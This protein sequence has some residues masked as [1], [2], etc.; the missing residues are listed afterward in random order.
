MFLAG[1]LDKGSAPLPPPLGAR[2]AAVSQAHPTPPGLPRPGSQGAVAALASTPASQPPPRAPAWGGAGLAAAAPAPVVCAGLGPGDAGSAAALVAAAAGAGAGAGAGAA[3]GAGAGAG[4]QG[5][6]GTGAGVEAGAG[7]QQQGSGAPLGALRELLGPQLLSGSI[8]AAAGGRGAGKR[9]GKG[10]A[11]AEPHGAGF[12]TPVGKGR[13]GAPQPAATPANLTPQFDMSPFQAA[14]GSPVP[15]SLHTAS[16]GPH[17]PL[18]QDGV[19]NPSI[20]SSSGP[21]LLPPPGPNPSLYAASSS[22]AGAAA[23]TRAGWDPHTGGGSQGQG[24]SR[25]PGSAPPPSLTSSRTPLAPAVTS[26]SQSGAQGQGQG[27]GLPGSGRA[28]L[29]LADFIVPKPS[30]GSSTSLNSLG[31]G[32]G[33]GKEREAG[34]PGREAAAAGGSGSSIRAGPPSSPGSSSAA[35][36]WG[37]VVPGSSPP[38]GLAPQLSLRDI[39]VEQEKRRATLPVWAGGRER[40]AKASSGGTAVLGSSPPATKW[41]VPEPLRPQAIQHIQTEESAIKALEKLYG[42]GVSV[43]RADAGCTGIGGAEVKRS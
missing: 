32:A 15:F 2:G 25:T 10:G 17:A 39:Q 3:A 28:G 20:Q 19:P 37:G 24:A 22:G 43:M 9:Q 33:Q 36:V 35:K 30:R 23:S 18:S 21:K 13:P 16:P 34:R 4:G 5:P 12:K 41:Y 11:A 27:Q 14:G 29:S 26:T 38:G 6:R 42:T 7:Q 8:S 40:S 1:A 31:Q